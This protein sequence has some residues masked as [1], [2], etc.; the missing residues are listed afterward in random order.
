MPVQHPSLIRFN[1]GQW[2]TKLRAR[3][4][5]EDYDASLEVMDG[6]IPLK[7][8]EAQAMTG[9]LY[10]AATKDPDLTSILIPFQY[11]ATD[12]FWIELANSIYA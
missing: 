10:G 11:S 8:G 1:G 7:Y 4:D 3:V 6:F 5:L 12:S 2:S 9:F